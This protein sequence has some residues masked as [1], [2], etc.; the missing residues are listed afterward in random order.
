MATYTKTNQRRLAGAAICCCV[1]CG[2]RQRKDVSTAL[3]GMCY[4]RIGRRSATAAGAVCNVRLEASYATSAITRGFH[5]PSHQ[6]ILLL[7]RLKQ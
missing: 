3:G 1:I 6:V 4:A 5:S 7:V 2:C